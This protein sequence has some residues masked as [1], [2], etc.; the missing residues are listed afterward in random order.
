MDPCGIAE[1]HL[2]TS[3]V[4]QKS[5]LTQLKIQHGELITEIKISEYIL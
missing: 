5:E 1:E 3:I 2:Y 4:E